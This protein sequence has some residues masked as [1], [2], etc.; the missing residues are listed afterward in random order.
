MS[1]FDHVIEA[2]DGALEDWSVSPDAMRWTPEP[3]EPPA[4]G[5]LLSWEGLAATPMTYHEVPPETSWLGGIRVV[6]DES[7]PPDQVRLVSD[8]RRMPPVDWETRERLQQVIAD[9]FDVP[10]CLA[11]GHAWGPEEVTVGVDAGPD[12]ESTI[13][14]YWSTCTRP[15]CGQWRIELRPGW[16]QA[17][18]QR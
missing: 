3:E 14:A 6:L 9:A 11:A 13:H 16:V 10:L 8:R 1:E 2:I 18:R 7:M 12:G 5:G 4:R 17:L 15:G